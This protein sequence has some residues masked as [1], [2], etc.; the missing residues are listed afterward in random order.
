MVDS[1]NYQTQA[2]GLARFLKIALI[3]FLIAALNF[4]GT[5]FA[6][7]INFQLFPRHDAMLNS[8][9]LGAIFL[10][11]LLMATPFMPGI[12]IGLALMLLLG[13]KGALLVYLC[14]LAALSI[15]FIVGRTIPPRLVYRFLKWLHLN[16]ASSLVHQL[17][18][19]NQQ[20]RLKFL[21]EKMPAKAAPILLKYRYLTIAAALNLPGNALIGGGGGICLVVGMSKIVPFHAFILLLA[22]AI[23][24]VPLW[25]YLFG[26]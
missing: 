12:E 10:Y 20:E 4:G 5:W 15:S 23:A 19:L 22:I 13:S 8:I 26:G 3:I 1:N 11:I 24:P 2:S 16:K 17:E 18:P 9:I 7:Q 21:N 25:F 14:T 6:H